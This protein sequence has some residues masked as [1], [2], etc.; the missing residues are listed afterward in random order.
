MKI[1]S[2][3]NGEFLCTT[4]KSKLQ[5]AL[6]HQFLSERSYWAKGRTMD[7]VKRSIE[8]SLCFGIYHNEQ[9]VAFAR[10]VS[11]FTVYAYLLDVFVLEDFRGLGMGKFLMNC[12]M[13]HPELQGLKRWMLGTED[14]H[15]LYKQYGFTSLKKVQNHMEKVMV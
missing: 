1:Q 6:I 5:K 10:V 15:G 14:A 2:W 9:Q 13:K 12:I 7:Q 3:K 8:H 11:D 4:D